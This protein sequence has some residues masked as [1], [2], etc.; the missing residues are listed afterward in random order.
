MQGSSTSY[1]IGLQDR[2]KLQP[3]IVRKSIKFEYLLSPK[4]QKQRQFLS[5]VVHF[6]FK[7]KV[8]WVVSGEYLTHQLTIHQLE[9]D[10]QQYAC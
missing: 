8:W 1:I 5:L 4:N 2:S 3:Q 9:A 7:Q 10:K 6:I